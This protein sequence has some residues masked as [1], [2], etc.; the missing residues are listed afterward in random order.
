MANMHAHACPAW[1]LYNDCQ[2]AKH[3][4]MLHANNCKEQSCLQDSVSSAWSPKQFLRPRTNLANICP[5]Y[6]HTMCNK[7]NMHH[8]ML[9]NAVN[10]TYP[11]Y[12]SHLADVLFCLTGIFTYQTDALPSSPPNLW[13]SCLIDLL[14]VNL[15]FRIIYTQNGV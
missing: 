9:I 4:T 14:G 7:T 12:Y 6:Q 2:R 5:C 8:S 10:H 15:H 13:G 1:H 11:N 3:V